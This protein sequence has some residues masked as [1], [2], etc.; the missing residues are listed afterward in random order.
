[1]DDSE[2]KPRTSELRLST[3]EAFLEQVA[4]FEDP[5]RKPWDEVWFRGQS[6][7]RWPLNTSLERRWKKTRAVADYG[8]IGLLSGPRR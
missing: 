5:T 7:A 1:M 8:R 2:P 3:W 4:K 6:D